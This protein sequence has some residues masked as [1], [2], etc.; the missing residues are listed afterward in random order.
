MTSEILF[1]E[2]N[3]I[4]TST[5]RVERNIAEDGACQTKC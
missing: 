5:F 1:V 3:K 4:L 2:T